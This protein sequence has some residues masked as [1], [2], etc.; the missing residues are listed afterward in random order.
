MKDML[1]AVNKMIDG[2]LLLSKLRFLNLIMT[3]LSFESTGRKN[4][5][6]I[7]YSPED[8]LFLQHRSM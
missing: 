7:Q 3:T 8:W 1:C 5:Q 4:G 6:F 2:K